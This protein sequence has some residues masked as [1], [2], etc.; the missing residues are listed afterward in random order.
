MRLVNRVGIGLAFVALLAVVGFYLF[1]RQIGETLFERAIAER[2]GRD[3][4]AELEDG[5]HVYMC[6]TGSPMSDHERAGPC[7]G[8]VAGEH[9]FLFD[10][11]SG[12][13][14]TASRMGFPVARTERLFLTH[15]HSDHFDGMGE[16]MV[17][18]WVGGGRDAPLPVWG[19]VGTVE[20]AEGFNAAYRIDSTYRTAHHGTAVA[21]PA[22]YGLAP[23]EIRLP[24]GAIRSVRLSA[25]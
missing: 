15:I 10:V 21:N 2:I 23:R 8:V 16:L 12:S 9:A 7:I 17:Q 19:P 18:A 20:T 24:D 5:L 25:G 6:G 22:G 14:R 11:G 4:M 1:Q 3:A 13:I